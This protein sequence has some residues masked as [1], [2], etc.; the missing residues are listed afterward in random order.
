MQIVGSSRSLRAYDLYLNGGYLAIGVVV[1][2]VLYVAIVL[3]IHGETARIHSEVSACKH[4]IQTTSQITVERQRLE[5]QLAENQQALAD[6]QLMIPSAPHEAEFLAQVCELAHRIGL[7][8]TDYHPGAVQERET[9]QELEVK[10]SGRGEYEAICRFLHQTDE[11]PRL[12][13][14]VHFELTAGE[15]DKPLAC[16]FTYHIFFIPSAESAAP[17]KETAS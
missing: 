13:R 8:V 12:C 9:Y 16:D 11:I 6:L 5:R 4:L 10:F 3:P 1:M 2:I 14:L 7:E 17:K 15:G